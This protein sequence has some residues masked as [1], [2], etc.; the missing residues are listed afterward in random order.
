MK[1][2]GKTSYNNK[3]IDLS[4]LR[5]RVITV[6]RVKTYITNNQFVGRCRR[7]VDSFKTIRF[8]I[9]KEFVFPTFFFSFFLNLHTGFRTPLTHPELYFTSRLSVCLGVFNGFVFSPPTL[10]V[11]TLHA[12]PCDSDFDTNGATYV[13]RATP[14]LSSARARL[15]TTCST[16]KFVIPHNSFDSTSPSP[17]VLVVS[18]IPRHVAIQRCTLV[19]VCL[20][21]PYRVCNP[22]TPALSGTVD[23]DEVRNKFQNEFQLV[24]RNDSGLGDECETRRNVGVNF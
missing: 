22:K 13:V 5:M 17:C 3:L 21:S 11:R 9:D 4:T 20:S 15:V 1:S 24:G 10:R 2:A 6:N 7:Q 19:F 16:C 8:H 14:Y 23:W 18:L 12:G